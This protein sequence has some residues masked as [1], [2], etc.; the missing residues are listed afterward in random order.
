MIKNIKYTMLIIVAFCLLSSC[1]QESSMEST[2]TN[3][4]TVQHQNAP[5]PS[6]NEGGTKQSI[7][8]YVESVTDESSADFIPE[9][10]RIATFDND[11]TLWSEQPA[12]F[13]LFFAMD[14]IKQ[15]AS[16]HPEWENEEPFRSVLGNDLEGLSKQ[17]L[18]GLLKV[19]MVSHSGM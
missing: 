2:S 10:D 19:V 16:D 8:N 9:S 12:Y 5:L 14:R 7:I 11:G 4:P 17:G 3:E 6:W 15:M 18:E 1:K 13:Q